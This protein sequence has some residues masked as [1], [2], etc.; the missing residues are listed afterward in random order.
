MLFSKES[1]IRTNQWKKYSKTTKLI[2]FRSFKDPK[3]LKTVILEKK[4]VWEIAFYIKNLLL[5]VM[6][7]EFVKNLVQINRTRM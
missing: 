5:I 1:S 3:A 2:S 4:H 7:G 6:G